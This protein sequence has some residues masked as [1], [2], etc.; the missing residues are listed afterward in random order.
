MAPLERLKE[1]FKERTATLFSIAGPMTEAGTLQALAAT[2]CAYLSAEGFS[3]CTRA[4]ED[5]FRAENSLL[6]RV[7]ERKTGIPISLA[8]VYREVGKASGLD[9]WGA[10]FPGHFFLGYGRAETAGLLDPFSGQVCT[11]REVA[12]I[13]GDL[14][15]HQVFL[16][17]GWSTSPSLPHVIFLRRMVRNLQT[18]Y[19]MDSNVAQAARLAQY[20]LILE[21]ISDPLLG[22]K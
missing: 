1:G 12:E 13:L 10:N 18:V 15:G 5:F 6:H 8:V 3:G 4:R 14:F 2:L 19:E 22:K 9:L 20:A 16:D 11:E 21:R 17:P 7:L